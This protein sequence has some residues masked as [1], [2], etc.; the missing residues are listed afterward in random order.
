MLKLLGILKS[1]GIK[2]YQSDRFNLD[3]IN[4]DTYQDDGEIF[5]ENIV[6]ETDN[7]S[8]NFVNVSTKTGWSLF[9]YFL[10]GSRYTYKIADMETSDGKFLPIVAG[11]LAT[12]V[13]QRIDSKIC[14]YDL[15]RMNV[16]MLSDRTNDDDFNDIKAEVLK[17]NHIYITLDKYQFKKN[18]DS[19]PENLAIARIQRLMME[20]EIDLLT[21]MVSTKLLKPDEMLVIDGSLQFMDK[22]AHDGLFANVIGISKSFNPNLQGL[23][24]RK[25][26]EIAVAL[27]KLK[28]GQRTPVYKYPMK[29][30]KRVIGAWY[31]RIRDEQQMTNPL[32][33]IVK[34]EKIAIDNHEKEEGFESGLVDNISKSIISERNVTCHGKDTRWPNHIYPMYLTEKM[35]KES[36]L[37]SHYFLNLF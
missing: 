30:N 13:C 21:N 37:S 9:K 18:P 14:K 10:D 35:L 34:I 7:K 16:L 17:F 33:G 31:L 15:K 26:Q 3:N 32:D 28:Y 23:L 5:P 24:K 2:C 29:D 8:G 25:T 22:K 19:R 4:F 11:Q 12:G 27:T 1:K 6:F 20:M 36:F